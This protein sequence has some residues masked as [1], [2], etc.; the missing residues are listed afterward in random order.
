MRVGQS[1]S[2]PSCTAR[3]VKSSQQQPWLW[4]KRLGQS[5]RVRSLGISLAWY[6]PIFTDDGGY[7]SVFFARIHAISVLFTFFNSSRLEV[8]RKYHRPARIFLVGS[9]KLNPKFSSD[10]GTPFTLGQATFMGTVIWTWCVPPPTLSPS[11]MANMIR[12]SSRLGT[13][14]SRTKRPKHI[15]RCGASSNRPSSS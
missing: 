15:S 13:E 3:V 6:K 9:F 10:T 1:A 11:V 8:Y 14:T 7:Q 2:P 12:P 5:W 4:A